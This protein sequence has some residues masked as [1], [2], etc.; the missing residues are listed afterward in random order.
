MRRDP[1]MTE[2]E[3]EAEYLTNATQNAML[4]GSNEVL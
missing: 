3:A 2:I 1:H 4:N